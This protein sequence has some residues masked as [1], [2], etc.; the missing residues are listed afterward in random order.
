MYDNAKQIE[1][2]RKQTGKY[3][4]RNLIDVDEVVGPGLFDDV[5]VK[6]VYSENGQIVGRGTL[7]IPNDTPIEN[8]VILIDPTD[9]YN[10]N[11]GDVLD[12]VSYIHTSTVAS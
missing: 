9:L 11:D 5:V 4:Q 10:Y 2:G 6:C 1:Y 7:S 12:E 3:L 8:G